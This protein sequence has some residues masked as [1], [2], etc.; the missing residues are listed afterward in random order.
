[1]KENREERKEKKIFVHSRLKNSEDELDLKSQEPRG[2]ST[3]ERFRK[4]MLNYYFI[5]LYF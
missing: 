4:K 1:M 5:S 2:K 3:P